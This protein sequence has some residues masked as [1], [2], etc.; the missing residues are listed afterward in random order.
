MSISVGGCGPAESASWPVAKR[1]RA[2]VP[3]ATSGRVG[4]FLRGSL[5]ERNALLTAYKNLDDELWPNLMPAILVTFLARLETIVVA[6]NPGA[7]LLRRDP[8]TGTVADR[9]GIRTAASPGSA[10]LDKLR[11]HGPAEF[12]RR[13]AQRIVRQFRRV[14]SGGRRFELAH[15]QAISHLRAMSLF[16]ALLD[17]AAAAREV[18]RQRRKRIRSRALRA[19]PALSDPDLPRGRGVLRQPRFL[20]PPSGEP[21]ARARHPRR[22]DGA[23]RGGP[24]VTCEVSV[25]IP[26]FNRRRILAEVLGALDGQQGAPPFEIVVV[27]DGS[28]DGT[29]E[30]LSQQA[31]SGSPRPLRL[32]RQ[33]NRGPAAARN[34]GVAAAA[35]AWIAFLGDDTVPEAD[36]LAP[37]LGETP[38]SRPGGAAGGDR[39]HR[40]AFPDARDAVPALHQ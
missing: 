22:G 12:A 9:A 7:E 13:A 3:S 17:D 29:F 20:E 40:L 25:V 8:F 37:A 16:L 6:G 31:A 27:D 32:L 35:G 4:P 36:W 2:I 33:P 23:A 34:R 19:F 14:V 18:A 5:F 1:W 39:L 30:W 24:P 11:R 15:P 28:T 10:W 26:T 38:G 21:G